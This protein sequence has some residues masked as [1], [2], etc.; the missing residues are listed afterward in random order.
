MLWTGDRM[1]LWDQEQSY[2]LCGWKEWNNGSIFFTCPYSWNWGETGLGLYPSLHLT[3]A[4]HSKMDYIVLGLCFQTTIYHI[5]RERKLR[6]H[7]KSWMNSFKLT[8]ASDTI[9][10]L[11]HRAPHKLEELLRRWFEMRLVQNKSR[12]WSP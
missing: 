3:T 12:K 7:H 8:S 11:K 4:R 6:W 1:R 2:M 5:W 9:L 10:L